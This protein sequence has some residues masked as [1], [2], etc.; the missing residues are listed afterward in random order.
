MK[1]IFFVVYLTSQSSYQDTFIHKEVGLSNIDCQHKL[2][3]APLGSLDND[4]DLIVIAK[5]IPIN[6]PS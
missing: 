6:T 3:Q 5:C 1:F 2:L 4:R